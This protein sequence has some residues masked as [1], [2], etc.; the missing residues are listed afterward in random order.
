VNI[1]D[2]SPDPAGEQRLQGIVSG[3]DVGPVASVLARRRADILAAWLEATRQQPFHAGRRERAIADHIPRLFDALVAVLERA[4]QHRVDPR[5][6]LDDPAVLNAAQ[7]H[8]RARFEQGLQPADVVT[9]FRLLRQQVGR[10]LRAD[11]GD[12]P[13]TREVIGAELLVNDAIDGAIT[14]GL[15]ALTAHVEEVREDFLATTIHDT[16]QPLAAIKALNQLAAR[17]LAR[18][19]L[20][21]E[22][23]RD[24]LARAT[25]EVDRMA[26]VLGTLSEVSRL[27]L[28]RLTLRIVSTELGQRVREAVQR[29]PPEA[30]S[31]VRLQLPAADTTGDWDPQMLDRVIANLLSNALKYSAEDAPIEVVLEAEAARLHLLVRDHGIGLSLDDLA[32]LFRRYGRAR[33]ATERG[34]QGLGLGLYLSHGIVEAHGGQLSAE[35]AG[36]G[37]G[38]TMHVWLPRSAPPP[39]GEQ[40]PP[41]DLPTERP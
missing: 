26:E 23:V 28:G 33:G 21:R 31:R 3:T 41:G 37:Q 16:Q 40:G 22:R 8:A 11:M 35:S 32:W 36:P 18:P 29:L 15:H 20:D 1:V 12:D 4:A 39:P 2:P 17:A 24:Y 19:D 13:P 14:L 38:T 27:T 25:G 34:V 6:P 5:A 10:A 30:A 7:G 9:E